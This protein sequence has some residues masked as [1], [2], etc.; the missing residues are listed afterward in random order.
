MAFSFFGGI[1]P[2]ENK[3]YTCDLPV[4]V[5]PAPDVVVIP[6]SQHIGAPCNPLVKKGDKVT[7]GQQIGCVGST[8][9]LESAMAE[10]VHFSVSRDGKTVDPEDFLKLGQ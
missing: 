8:A 5:F 6:M 2:K 3:L 7:L 1:H 10:H 9:L 4:Q